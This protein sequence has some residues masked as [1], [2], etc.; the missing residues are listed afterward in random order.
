M[1]RKKAPKKKKPKKANGRP[2]FERTPEKDAIFDRL[3]KAG[4]SEEMLAAGIG[5]DPKTLRKYYPDEIQLTHKQRGENVAREIYRRGMA[6]RDALL[7]F[8]AK[9]QLGWSEKNAEPPAAKQPPRMISMKEEDG[10]QPPDN[11]GLAALARSKTP[12]L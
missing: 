3:A 1:A 8:Y 4:A 7:M 5:I 10:Q 2:A 6:G 11:A 12:A 9:C